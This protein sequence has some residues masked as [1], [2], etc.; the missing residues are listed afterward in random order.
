MRSANRVIFSFITM[1]AVSA[2]W[3]CGSDTASSTSTVTMNIK[4]LT[5]GSVNSFSLNLMNEFRGGFRAFVTGTDYGSS[6]VQTGGLESYKLSIKGIKFCNSL[7]ISGTA[8]S[9]QSGCSTIYSNE[10]DDYNTFS[11][12]SAATAGSGKYFDILSATDRNSLT[13]SATI[14]SGEYNYGIIDW[15]RP[16][17]IKATIPRSSGD[18][19]TTG[20]T[21]YSTVNGNNTCIQSNFTGM[22]DESIVDLNNGGTWFKFLKPF[23]AGTS[24]ASVD[25]AFDLEEKVFGGKDVSNGAIQTMSAC[26]GSSGTV[27]GIYVPIL[28][29]VPVPRGSTESTMVE[30][31]EMGGV[32]SEWKVRVDVYYNSADTSKTVLAADIYAIPTS[33]I[34]SSI[35]A[36]LYVT[37]VETSGVTTTFKNYDGTSV[38]TFT[39]DTSGSGTL[40]CP[41][42][43]TL[44]GCTAGS[45]ATVSWTTRSVRSL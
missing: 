27:C 16:I 24:A 44:V 25:L 23:N 20:C 22:L 41:S 26:P 15:Y 4:S 13:T 12:T 36:G 39:R 3:G 6:P 17:K 45:T 9:N 28:K 29:V 11:T 35:A 30:T 14:A 33:S 1:V 31:Y 21:S 42:R 7:T 43:A 8:Y 5:S 18:L 10:A 34:A 37:D 19:K 38:L 32:S 40:T 2:L